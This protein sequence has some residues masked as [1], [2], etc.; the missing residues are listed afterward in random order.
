MSMIKRAMNMGRL[1]PEGIAAYLKAHDEI[2]PD[3]VNALHGAGMTTISCFLAGVDLAVYSEAHSDGF[4]KGK[5]ELAQNKAAQEF[6]NSMLPL[7]EPGAK[8]IDFKEV[9]YM[10]SLTPGRPIAREKRVLSM[11]KLKDHAVP[12]YIRRHDEIKPELLDVFHQAGILQISCFL[13]QTTLL[14]YS[15]RNDA[16]YPAQEPGLNLHPLCLE[17]MALVKPL[18]D[19]TVAPVDLPEVFRLPEE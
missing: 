3:F 14:I 9:F 18:A 17:F 5:E 7:V 2:H 10:P 13:H 19:P 12:E 16:I 4:T 1:K 15:V 11:V 6:G 8:S